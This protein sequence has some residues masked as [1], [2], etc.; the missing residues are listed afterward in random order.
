MQQEK[1]SLNDISLKNTE[2]LQEKERLCNK[3]RN[4]KRDPA[5]QNTN[6]KN[7]EKELVLIREKLGKIPTENIALRK[8]L[9]H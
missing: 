5:V 4:L 9:S 7:L 1:T 2:P 3:N 8:L 6:L